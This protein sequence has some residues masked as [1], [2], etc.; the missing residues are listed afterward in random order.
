MKKTINKI[1]ALSSKS[2]ERIHFYDINCLHIDIK[3]NDVN[4]QISQHD[5]SFLLLCI[6]L[7]E[8]KDLNV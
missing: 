5:I 8:N 6:K 7:P 3:F 4:I 1:W 2:V